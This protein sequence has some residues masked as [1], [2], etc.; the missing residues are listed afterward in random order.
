MSPFLVRDI[1]EVQ[2]FADLDGDELVAIAGLRV[3]MADGRATV[4]FSADDGDVPDIFTVQ[5]RIVKM[6]VSAV[7]IFAPWIRLGRL[8][9]TAQPKNHGVRIEREADIAQQMNGA[10][11]V[12]AIGK[13]HRAATIGIALLDGFVN[14]GRVIGRTVAR[15]AEVFDVVCFVRE[16]GYWEIGRYEGVSFR[17]KRQRK[18]R[19][20]D[21]EYRMSMAHGFKKVSGNAP[22]TIR[23]LF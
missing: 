13:I 11:A 20:Q 22:C 9:G 2:I 7:L 3:A 21:G 23:R 16:S 1:F 17:P 14:G 10:R 19:E 8:K 6:A 12:P 5:K 15:R 18:K 4:N